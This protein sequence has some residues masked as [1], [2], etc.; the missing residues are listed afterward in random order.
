MSPKQKAS[1]PA[2]AAPGHGEFQL[3]APAAGLLDM[4]TARTRRDLDASMVHAIMDV[5]QPRSVT[6]ARLVKTPKGERWWV[7]ARLRAGE[8]AALGD[9]EKDSP[10]RMGNPSSYPS[11]LEALISPE[12]ITH[13][14][15][16]GEQGAGVLTTFE[17]V[18]ESHGPAVLE[19]ETSAQTITNDQRLITAVLRSYRHMDAL[20]SHPHRDPTTGLLN[21]VALADTFDRHGLFK[22]GLPL[23]M[24]EGGASS[25]FVF[26]GDMDRRNAPNR[27]VYFLGVLDIDRFN[28]INAFCGHEIGDQVLVLTVRILRNSFRH[29]DRFFRLG[30]DEIATVIRCQNV[31]DATAA[32]ERFRSQFNRFFFPNVG[33]VTGSIGLTQIRTVDTAMSALTRAQKAIDEAKEGGRDRIVCLDQSISSQ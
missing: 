32:F 23:F 14:T 17:L 21:H 15:L 5:L 7:S 8:I 30:A 19:I 31:A 27:P 3:T 33:F 1:A 24:E 20:V 26:E 25:V 12:P 10:E 13:A 6:I 4:L 11:R 16:V 2:Q 9:S 18:S 29:R 28:E 22:N